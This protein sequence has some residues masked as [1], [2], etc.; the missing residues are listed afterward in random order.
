M[1]RTVRVVRTVGEGRRTPVPTRR[2]MALT[3]VTVVLIRPVL[4]A[5]RLWATRTLAETQ[6]GIKHGAAE[7]MAVVL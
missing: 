3:I 7:I 1:I 5:T 4:G 2:I 6:S